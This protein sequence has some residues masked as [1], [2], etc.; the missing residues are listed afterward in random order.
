MGMNMIIKQLSVFI[1]NRE[2]RLRTVTKVLK[3]NKIDMLSLSLADTSEFGILRLIVSDNDLA[4]R[5]LKE[6]GFSV[7]LTDVLSIQSTCSVGFLN[8]LLECME[9][10]TNIEYM[11]TLPGEK[12]AVLIMK[13]ADPEKVEASLRANNFAV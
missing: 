11:Y 12:G 8:D 5:V 6:A 2:G 7:S 1:E 3:D 4:K 13:V 9:S 10:N